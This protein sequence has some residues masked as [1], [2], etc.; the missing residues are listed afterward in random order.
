MYEETAI[1]KGKYSNEYSHI[2]K[3]FDSIGFDR[4]KTINDYVSKSLLNQGASYIVYGKDNSINKKAFPFDLIP[5]I[6]GAKEW[7]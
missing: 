5:R 4:F 2:F 7:Q 6:I 3:Y 1:L